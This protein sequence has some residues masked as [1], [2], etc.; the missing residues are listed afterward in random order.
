[1]QELRRHGVRD[2]VRVCEPTYSARRLVDA[3]IAVTDLPFDDGTGPPADV[4]EGFFEL[5]RA[6]L[7][8]EPGGCVAVHCVAGLGRS[9]SLSFDT[10]LPVYF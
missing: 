10:I 7:K 8:R 9:A 1:M 3:G 6:Q 4:I 2:V 5:V